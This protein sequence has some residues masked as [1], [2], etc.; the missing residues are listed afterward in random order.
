LEDANHAAFTAALAE[1]AQATA[2]RY[3]CRL[4]ISLA[5]AEDLFQDSLG[6]AW[7]SFGRLRNRAAFKPWL[8][9]IVRRRHLMDLRQRRLATPAED[10]LVAPLVAEPDPQAELVLAGLRQL[11]APQREALELF[12]IEGLNLAELGLVLGVP[13]IAAR[14][15]L[16][17][18]REALRRLVNA[19]QR[20][21]QAPMKETT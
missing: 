8:L 14:H 6:Q 20:A 18:A 1:G 12:Y 3:C 7:A 19:D 15:R 16:H 10:E 11:P 21:A 2:W 17:R 13:A 9:S 4:R 5:D